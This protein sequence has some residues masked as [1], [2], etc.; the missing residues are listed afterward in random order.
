MVEGQEVCGGSHVAL[1]VAD[2]VGQ[3]NSISVVAIEV[4][5]GSS[6]LGCSCGSAPSTYITTSKACRAVDD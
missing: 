5:E 1:L 6:T 3:A 2:E 4:L